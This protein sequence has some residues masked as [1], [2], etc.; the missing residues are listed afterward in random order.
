MTSHEDRAFRYAFL[1]TALVLAVL[2]GGIYASKALRAHAARASSPI[3]MVRHIVLYSGDG[4][5]IQEWWTNGEVYRHATGFLSF[6]KG[7]GTF[8]VADMEAPQP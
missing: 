7:D 8:T 2:T 3:P 1:V 4:T 6:Q 5:V